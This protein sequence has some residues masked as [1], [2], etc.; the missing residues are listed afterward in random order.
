MRITIMLLIGLMIWGCTPIQKGDFVSYSSD[1]YIFMHNRFMDKR[2]DC[3]ELGKMREGELMVKYCIGKNY[4]S[5]EVQG[6]L[7]E[8]QYK[9]HEERFIGAYVQF[10]ADKP[11]RFK[12]SSETIE[13]AAS[14]TEYVN[15][16]LPTL[17]F[18]MYG[19]IIN[20]NENVEGEFSGT[21]D[22]KNVFR[23]VISAEGKELLKA[24]HKAR[25]E[26]KKAEWKK[27]SL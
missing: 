25:V 27:G 19:F 18:D 10:K 3:V 4:A 5:Q 13:G 11:I 23:G 7:F 15:C 22:Q 20:S 12:C 9:S 24:F 17:G 8:H 16:M 26:G 21:L 14:G 6:F 2:M 1:E